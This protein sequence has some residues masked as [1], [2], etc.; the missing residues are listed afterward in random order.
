MELAK[1]VAFGIKRTTAE[2]FAERFNIS[3]MEGVIFGP[4][5]DW[6][7]EAASETLE[8]TFK[9]EYWLRIPETTRDNIQ[10]QLRNGIRDGHSIR[11]IAANIQKWG[12]GEYSRARATNVA[13]SEVGNALNAGH[14]AGMRQLQ[15]ESG[16]AIGKEWLSVHG[17]TTRPSHS[18]MDGQRTGDAD[19]MFTLNGVDIPWPGHH[20]LGPEDRCHCQCTTISAISGQALDIDREPP[21][22]E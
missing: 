9:Q 19:G 1:S 17:P 4:L 14:V 22:D 12:G 3:A 20:A 8:E 13:R 10:T 18:A 15:E 16:L 6:L 21:P 2:E 7:L 5:P 11:D